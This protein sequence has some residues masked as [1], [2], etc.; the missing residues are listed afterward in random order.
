MRPMPAPEPSKVL[1]VRGVPPDLAKKLKAAAA[2]EGK[3]LQAYLV[4][5]LQAHVT[6]LERKGYLPKGRG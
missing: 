1:Y 2:L 4:K 6:D 3:S 5:M